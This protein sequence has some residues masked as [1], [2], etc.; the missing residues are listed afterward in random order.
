MPVPNSGFGKAGD[1]RA[2]EV[3]FS[4][5]WV[6]GRADSSILALGV[7]KGLARVMGEIGKK[8]QQKFNLFFWG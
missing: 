6:K 1:Q 5:P 4:E 2:S 8:R 3:Y 7:P